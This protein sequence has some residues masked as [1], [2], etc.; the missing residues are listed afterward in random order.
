MKKRL[1]ALWAALLLL[2]GGAMAQGAKTAR[3]IALIA[4]YTDELPGGAR[5]AFAVETDGALWGFDLSA[6]E[7][8]LWQ[9]AET[10]T[11]FLTRVDLPGGEALHISCRSA[12]VEP[13]LMGQA[14]QLR[15]AAKPGEVTCES[16]M[17]GAGLIYR[18]AVR[19]A[20]GQREILY[21]GVEGNSEGLTTDDYGASLFALMGI[22]FP[23]PDSLY[24]QSCF[25]ELNTAQPS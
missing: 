4:M 8:S 5:Y 11:G 21:L 2:C 19:S 24:W 1:A 22:L 10:L 14:L 20:D 16:V 3:D 25:A 17:Q 9:D 6:Q 18:Y 15:Q 23:A 7:E 13:D 12:D